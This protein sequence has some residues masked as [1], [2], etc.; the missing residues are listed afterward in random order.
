LSPPDRVRP[1]GSVPT[2]TDHEYGGDPPDAASAC[3]YA[4][5]TI[6][7]GNDAVVMLSAGG[8]IVNDSAAVVDTDALSVTFT[9]KLLDPAVPGVPEIVPPVDRVNPEGRVPTDTNHEYGGDPPEAASACEYA[10]PTIPAGNDAVVIAKAGLIVSDSAFVVLPF[11]LS[12]TFTV[13]LLDPALP[14]VPDI[15]PPADSVK[16]EGSVPSDTVHVYGADPPEAASACEY[17]VLTAPAGR[18]AVVIVKAG[19][20]VSDKS[21][22]VLPFAL[23]VTF[24]VKLFDP[25]VPGVPEIVP[26]VDRFNPEGSVPADTVHVYGADPPEAVSACE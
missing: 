14:G 20:I 8:L 15:V 13:K 21:F 23:S 2:D 10:V 12:V 9:V 25:A 26:P 5:P 24:T 11:A 4:V 22:V 1:E 16:P 7:A 6:P 3:E 19:L 17:A 18:D